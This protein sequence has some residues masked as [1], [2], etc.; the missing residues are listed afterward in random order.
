MVYDWRGMKGI[1]G[2]SAALLTFDFAM[3]LLVVDGKVA[4]QYETDRSIE[5]DYNTI[6]DDTGPLL[7][8]VS[9]SNDSSHGRSGSQDNRYRIPCEVSGIL[10]AIPVLHCFREARFHMAMHLSFAQ[11]VLIGTLDA[12][13]PIEAASLFGFSSREV[14]FMFVALMLPYLTLG[15]FFG[16]AVDKYGTRSVATI[17]Y[18]YLIPWL[19]LLGLPRWHVA[20]GKYDIVLFCFVLAMNGIGLAAVSSSTFVEAIE[21]VGKYEAASPDIFGDNGPYSQ[22]F[23]FNSLYFFAGLAVGPVVGG[24]LREHFG[25]G[26]TGVA[27]GL[28]SFVTAI[29]S[30]FILAPERHGRL[31]ADRLFE[32]R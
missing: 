21:I 1:F 27:L 3:R 12:T 14:G 30:F 19:L 8:A 16:Q 10:K 26:L 29:M 18:L 20:E 23:G 13:V 7:P 24:A 31:L 6:V 22:L 4:M 25:Y 28:F 15:R 32:S 17:S 5:N 2:I 9:Q 11:A